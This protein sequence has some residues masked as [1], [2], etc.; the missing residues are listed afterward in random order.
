M[1]KAMSAIGN[2]GGSGLRMVLDKKKIIEFIRMNG[3]TIPVQIVKEFGQDTIIIGA[4]L[5]ELTKSGLI[6][7]SDIKVGGSPLYYIDDQK[8]K[9][10]NF[11]DHLNEKDKEAYDLL[12]QKGI[13]YDGSL[14]PLLRVSMRMIKD[15]AI[16]LKVEVHGKEEL[17]WRWYLL[18]MQGIEDRIRDILMPNMEEN[19]KEEEYVQDQ[20]QQQPVS[21]TEDEIKQASSE[22][23]A[24]H[25][26]ETKKIYSERSDTIQKQLPK[27]V[28]DSLHAK[29][30]ELF[31]SK[32]IE[33]TDIEVIRKGSEIN[34][35]IEVPSSVGRIMYC[36]KAKSKKKINDSDIAAAYVYGETRKLPVLFLTTG[37]LTKKAE[38]TYTK[39]ANFK[40]IKLR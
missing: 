40:V 1:M 16:P 2:Q 12:K 25:T 39:F 32:E 18:P 17:F 36:A 4:V 15:F 21:C 5:S 14:T 7:V 28:E 26:P 13:L 34:Y 11:A 8:F 3:P 24:D 38:Q 31:I 10:Q 23:S 29:V 35:E 37:E 19:S 33:I 20:P 22:T 30:K 6:S 27:D 9:L